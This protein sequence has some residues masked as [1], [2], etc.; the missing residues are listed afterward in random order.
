MKA[1]PPISF[2][3]SSIRLVGR[4]QS[5]GANARKS[6]TALSYK[7]KRQALHTRYRGL[8]NNI[9]GERSIECTSLSNRRVGSQ[10]SQATFF[11]S[12]HVLNKSWASGWNTEK[13]VVSFT[14]TF[15]SCGVHIRQVPLGQLEIC[16]DSPLKMMRTIHR[17]SS[18]VVRLYTRC[19]MLDCTSL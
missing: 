1:R 16:E 13:T 12:E 4:L 11:K 3:D 15:K 19:R 17:C 10:S 6:C 18:A 5:M 2:I 8:G 14:E 7:N 9:S